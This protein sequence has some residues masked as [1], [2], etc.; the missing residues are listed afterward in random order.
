[1]SDFLPMF[2]AVLLAILIAPHVQK[3]SDTVWNAVTGHVIV[4]GRTLS[5]IIR[6]IAES[7]NL[8]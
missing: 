1:M 4:A 6:R 2:L 3:H 8:F 7:R 5:F